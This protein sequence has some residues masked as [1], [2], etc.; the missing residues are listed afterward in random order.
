ML[1]QYY[2]V[3]HIN[4]GCGASRLFALRSQ[5]Q[6]G[7]PLGYYVPAESTA[8]Q[9]VGERLY[10]VAFGT[11]AKEFNVTAQRL[12]RCSEVTYTENA[13][14]YD[15]QPR[16]HW[17]NQLKVS[18][19]SA[20]ETSSIVIEKTSPNGGLRYLTQLSFMPDILFHTREQLDKMHHIQDLSQ[21]LYYR[22]Q[23][24]WDIESG[25]FVRYLDATKT[26]D[27]QQIFYN[28]ITD[29]I[30]RAITT[31]FVFSAVEPKWIQNRL[32]IYKEIVDTFKTLPLKTVESIVMNEYSP[33]YSC[34][35]LPD[36]VYL[37]REIYCAATEWLFHYPALIPDDEPYVGRTVYGE[38]YQTPS[39]MMQ[40][41]YGS[42]Q[43]KLEEN[44]QN[45]EYV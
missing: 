25:H 37:K 2:T 43:T 8:Q 30:N 1:P 45:G 3:E 29:T 13:K 6:R 18:I 24:Y 11:E 39:T 4:S 40:S 19:P 31:S 44:E 5:A 33:I 32:A 16:L 28:N 7:E 10:S 41:V 38:T 36:M 34:N 15:V 17:K 9:G 21:Q 23:E 12:L 42:A 20:N 14:V 35:D 22:L 27:S 26:V